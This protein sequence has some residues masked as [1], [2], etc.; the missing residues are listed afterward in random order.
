M[1]RLT[2]GFRAREETA[3]EI[4]VE[5]WGDMAE[6]SEGT[7]LTIEFEVV[8]DSHVSVET[9]PGRLV[10]WAPAGA[11][12]LRIGDWVAPEGYPPAP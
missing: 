11:R 1:T 4:W 12:L 6:L 10:V 5:P 2:I 8:G 9:K 7:E 3:R